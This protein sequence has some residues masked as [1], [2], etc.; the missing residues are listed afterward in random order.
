MQFANRFEFNGVKYL[1]LFQNRVN[2]NTLVKVG[3]YWISP[4]AED[5]RTY[6]ICIKRDPYQK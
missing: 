5:V 4:K 1:V 6:G 3:D 2:P